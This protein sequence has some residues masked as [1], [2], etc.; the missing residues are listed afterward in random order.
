MRIKCKYYRGYITIYYKGGK[1]LRNSIDPG[2]L[3]KVISIS[4]Q[5][6]ENMRYIEVGGKGR[7]G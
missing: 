2:G 5:G 6:D 3:H 1:F 7:R 4:I